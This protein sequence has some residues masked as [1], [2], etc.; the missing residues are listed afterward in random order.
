MKSQIE[1]KNDIDFEVKLKVTQDQINPE[2]IRIRTMQL[3]NILPD[4]MTKKEIEQ[5][6]NS[7]ISREL[8]HNVIMDYLSKQYT[9]K[10]SESE[11]KEIQERVKVDIINSEKRNNPNAKIDEKVID[12]NA[13][14]IASRIIIKTLIYELIAKENNIEVSDEELNTT[15][16]NYKK[17]TGQ[18]VD[19]L[20]NE[21]AKEETRMMIKEN[22][23][24][25]FLLS[26]FKN[27][28]FPKVPGNN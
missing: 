23:V 9:Y 18:A 22:K 13:R 21:Q 2:H 14:T 20:S 6:V 25:S 15:L 16:E 24:T 3:M 7:M 28:E 17:E 27:I 10:I 12:T 19:V 8:A 1:K 5:R 11:L 26:K 4:T